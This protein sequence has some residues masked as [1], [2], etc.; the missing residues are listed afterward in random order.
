[1]NYLTVDGML[2]GTGIRDS[3]EGG[4]LDPCEFGLPGEVIDKISLWLK[5]Y[6]NAHYLQYEDKDQVAKLDSEGIEICRILR[7]ALPDSKLN[8]IQVRKLGG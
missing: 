8:T 5:E 7:E 4:Y 6:E 1:M 2:S 3:I